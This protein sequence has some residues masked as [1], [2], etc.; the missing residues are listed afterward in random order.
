MDGEAW[1]RWASMDGGRGK[2]LVGVDGLGDKLEFAMKTQKVGLFQ[3]GDHFE[4]A[5]LAELM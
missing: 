1:V 3:N 2:G 5:P 4:T